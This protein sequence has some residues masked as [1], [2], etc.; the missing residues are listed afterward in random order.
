MRFE[1]P[2]ALWGLL[3]ILLLA[4]F[5]LWRQA[6]VRAVVPSL[7]L[8][9]MIP[10][11][12]PPLRA[13]RRPRWRLSL[14]L[15]AA[16]LASMVGGAAGPYA[17]GSE[18]E[19][20]RI[21]LVFDTSARMIE[22]GRLERAVGTARR[23]LGRLGPADRISIYAAVP[24]PRRLDS[25]DEVRAVHAHVDTR[26]L[27]AAARAEADEV[28]YFSDRPPEGAV[29]AGIRM[30]LFGG[31]G[32][33]VGIVEFSASDSGVFGRVVNH[34][35]ARRV[36]IELAAGGRVVRE[37]VDLSPG[38]TAWSR[39][40]DLSGAAGV[41]L[42]V[43]AGDSFPLDDEAHAVRLGPRR[44]VAALSG[45]HVPDLVRALEAVGGVVLRRGEGDC[46][47]AVGIDEEPSRRAGLRVMVRSP[48][49][50]FRP[51]AVAVR[52]HPLTAALRGEDFGSARVGAVDL[53]PGAEPLLSAD[54]RIFGALW[55]RT[56]RLSIDMAPSGWPATI[57]FPVFWTNVIDYVRRGAGG[58]SV[59][60]TGRPF[61][62]PPDV[63]RIE[64][65]SAGTVYEVS[66]SRVLIVHTAGVLEARGAW[67]RGE[68]RP[69]LLD[70][71]ESDTAGTER[72]LD[73]DPADPAGRV[74]GRRPL[75]GA[76]AALALVLAAAGWAL[77]RRSE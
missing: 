31:K 35:P 55:D 3:S 60:R 1:T 26:P 13:L 52:P 68:I 2:T 77:E 56:L 58:F 29:G 23:L 45:R 21:A 73:W 67:G 11:R 24:S 41:S 70:P 42:R 28:V 75:G 12:N 62:L 39:S 4:I 30:A 48:E 61:E 40:E 5:S 51:A 63:E 69:C 19:P 9:K 32:G 38:E 10:E 46:Q 14:L 66:P 15:Q 22:N 76:S 7:L 50:G 64:P 74:P 18:P 72:P 37:R 6:A 36:D 27:L 43:A 53:P 57:S 16:A 17:A 34:G 44:I 54:G 20:R 59:V 8:W 25:I 33:N 71:R 47:V 49:P 65:R